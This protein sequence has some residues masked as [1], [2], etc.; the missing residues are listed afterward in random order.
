M[1]G[2]DPEQPLK[3]PGANWAGYYARFFIRRYA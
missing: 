3:A 1:D 2:A